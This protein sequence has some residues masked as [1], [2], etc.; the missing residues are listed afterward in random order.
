MIEDGRCGTEMKIRIAQAKK[1]FTQRKEWLTK[2]FSN[3]VK[4]KNSED[5]GV[6]YTVH[7]YIDVKHG[8]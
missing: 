3:V 6:D 5:T 2:R 4:K 7:N 8:C 1:A